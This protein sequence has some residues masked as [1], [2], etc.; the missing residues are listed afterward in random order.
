VREFDGNRPELALPMA[1]AVMRRPES[2]S[3]QITVWITEA[4]ERLYA[5]SP[6]N[7]LTLPLGDRQVELFVGGVWRDYA[8]QFGAIAMT[9]QD[10]TA[11]GQ[12][13]APSDAALWPVDEIRGQALLA[14]LVTQGGLEKSSRQ[15]IRS[16]SLRIFD[17]SFAVTYALE[18]AA[19]LIGLFGLAVT[20]AASVELRQRE[21]AM[22]AAM[23]FTSRSLQHTVLAEGAVITLVG[24]AI[25][26]ACGVAIGAVLIHVVNPQAFHWTMSMRMPW[27]VFA[28]AIVLTFAASLAASALAARRATRVPVATVLGQAQ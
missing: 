8:R 4:M 1:S 16:L 25:G 2:S 27:F 19:I 11:L 22:L 18:A 15:E 5:V 7:T 26:C 14:Q 17:R 20:L 13:F 24:L 12:A 28:S 10:Y 9:A 6:G 23:G 3:A 21:L